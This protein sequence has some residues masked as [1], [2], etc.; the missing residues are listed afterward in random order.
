MSKKLDPDVLLILKNQHAIMTTLRSM[1]LNQGGGAIPLL[2]HQLNETDK[3]IQYNAV[4][5][6]ETS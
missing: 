3:A 5:D 2:V 1:I 6:N 4:K